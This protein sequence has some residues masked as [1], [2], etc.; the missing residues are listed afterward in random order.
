VACF[1]IVVLSGVIRNLREDSRPDD[2]PL[3]PDDDLEVELLKS[4]RQR[5][6]AR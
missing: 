1:L 6:G 4:Q 2:E 3:D 5:V